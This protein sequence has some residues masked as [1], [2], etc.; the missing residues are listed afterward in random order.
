VI[1]DSSLSFFTSRRVKCRP[2]SYRAVSSS[3]DMD[4]IAVIPVVIAG[5]GGRRG[6]CRFDADER[7]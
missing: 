4:R 5:N 6:L 7:S 3:K 1:C 2:M